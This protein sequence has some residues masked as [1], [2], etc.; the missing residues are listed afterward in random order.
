MEWFVYIRVLRR[1]GDASNQSGLR[2]FCFASVMFHDLRQRLQNKA[3][4]AAQQRTAPTAL[5]HPFLQ[6]YFAGSH[7]C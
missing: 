3:K 6:E 1:A 5:A 4:D 7:C 2:V